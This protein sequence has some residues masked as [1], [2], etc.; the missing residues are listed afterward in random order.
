MSWVTLLWS[1]DSAFCFTLA[2]IYLLVWFKHQE[3]W[4][5][6]LFSCSALAAGVIA[7][8]EA[9]TMRAETTAQYSA[10]LRWAHLPVW[11]VILSVVGFAPL[12]LRAGRRWLVVTVCGL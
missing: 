2:G 9:T 7:R 10:I 5:H 12:D 4:E 8:L 11:M 3:A 1:M 6:L